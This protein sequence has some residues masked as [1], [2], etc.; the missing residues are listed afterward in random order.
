VH[1]N[2]KDGKAYGFAFDDVTGQESL[3]HSGGPVKASITLGSLE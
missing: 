1:A 3:V 2:M